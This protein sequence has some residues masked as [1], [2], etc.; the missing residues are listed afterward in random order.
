[1]I[2]NSF[3]RYIAAALIAG[4]SFSSC[5]KDFNEINTNPDRQN[6]AS[7][8]WFATNM[9][10]TITSK[11]IATGTDFI[12]PFTLCKY[13]AWTE[14]QNNLQYNWIDRTNFD[15]FL[16]LRDI[17]P[18]VSFAKT[19]ELQNSYKALGHFIRAW[20]FFRATMQL[21]DIPYSEAIKGADKIIKPKY[22]SQKDVFLGILN[23]LDAADDLFS[24]GA[25]FS[26]DFIYKGSTDKWRRLTNTFQLHVLMNLYKKTSDTDLRVVQ[27]FNQVITRPLMRDYND[28]FAVTYNSSAGYCYPWSST[29]AQINAFTIYPMV[30][31]TLIDLLK[32]NQ[33]RRL[34]YYTEPAR[35]LVAAGKTASDYDAYVGVEPSDVYS[36]TLNAH[37]SG[38]FCDVNKRYVEMYNAEP[39]GLLNYW[40]LQFIL[41]EAAV[42]GWISGTPAQTYYSNG[43]K[44]SMLFLANYA[45][46]GYAHGMAISSAYADTYAQQVALHG[47]SEDQIRQIISQKYIAGFF[48]NVDYTAWFEN[49]RTGYPT[50]V[51]NSA[52]NQNTPAAKFPVRWLYP[53]KELEFNSDNVQAAI[54]SQ[55]NGNDDT[56]Q[57]MWILK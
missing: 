34:F 33:D 27:K 18:M 7:S 4:I 36:N 56:N 29:P 13:L 16:V 39:V 12:Q 53:Q 25:D 26:G 44:G 20:V 19:P 38:N 23:E 15:R 28:N 52:T 11:N 2:N 46:A 49:R 35:A 57:L 41:A 3:R 31:A 1:M 14:K 22:D 37:N 54:T 40:D 10:T 21:G 47:S 30:S 55:Y 48:H 45:P 32:A 24:K 17:D 5:T 51:L 6:I 9:L 42:R 50:F 43:I 8:E